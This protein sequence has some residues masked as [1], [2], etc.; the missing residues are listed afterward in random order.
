[1]R[2]S[3]LAP[4]LLMLTMGAGRLVAQADTSAPGHTPLHYDITLVR[5]D[6]GP[7]VLAE[8]ETSWRLG[9]TLPV[10]VDLDSN[11]RVVRVFVDG[12]PNTRIS[13]TQ[14]A[15]G[16]GDVLVPHEK[17]AGDTLTTRIRYHG[18]P[19]GG[20]RAGPNQYGAR[21]LVA[22]ALTADPSLWLPVPEADR[23][24]AS[25]TFHVQA[26]SG[27]RVIT[28]GVLAQVDTLAYGHTRWDY[29]LDQAIPLSAIAVAAG[30]YVTASLPRA[31]CT[32]PCAPVSV[33]TWSRDSAFAVGGP[34]RRAAAMMDFFSRL[35]GPFPYSALTHVEAAITSG[36]VSGASVILYP[37]SSLRDQ[38]LD[39]ATVARATARQWLRPGAPDS[40]AE[41]LA[42]LWRAEADGKAKKNPDLARIRGFLR[43]P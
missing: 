35:L 29:R 4:A 23:R 34:F 40:A 38:T 1:V 21:T 3:S 16:A 28:A 43:S 32:S 2:R 13:R 36:A 37:E 6:S 39:E 7:H 12:K 41:Y 33:W 9:S 8:V 30:P 10:V 18:V 22:E 19:R 31:G 14:F 25:V 24:T 20:L 15:R 17:P 27:E 11:F 26:D 5:S 42:G